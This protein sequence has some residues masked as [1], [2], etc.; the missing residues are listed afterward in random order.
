VYSSL[1]YGTKTPMTFSSD[2]I[3]YPLK[4]RKKTMDFGIEITEVL[5]YLST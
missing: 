3:G 2:K 5:L 1:K 4:D